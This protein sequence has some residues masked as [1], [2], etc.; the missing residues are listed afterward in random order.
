ML[1]APD[2]FQQVG[3]V[4]A[5]KS[6][7]TTRED[8]LKTEDQSGPLQH[9]GKVVSRQKHRSSEVMLCDHGAIMN[10]SGKLKEGLMVFPS[11]STSPR[12]D[13]CARYLL[14]K[15]YFMRCMQ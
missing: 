2:Q 3:K 5:E 12:W 8:P 9:L 4:N 13:S 14:R 1:M 7:D 11:Q 10:R 6:V 15:L